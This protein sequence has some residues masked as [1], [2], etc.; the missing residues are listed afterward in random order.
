MHIQKFILKA[1]HVLDPLY[2]KVIRLQ[3]L[4][5]SSS[6]ELVFRIRLTK[7]KGKQI[8]LSDGTQIHKNDL[9]IKIHL[10]NVK[11]LYNVSQIHPEHRKA[12]EIYRMVKK[13]MPQ[14]ADF[15]K[16]HP[17]EANIKGIIGITTINK[18]FHSLGFEG[19][20]PSNRFYTSFKK[21]FQ[22][23]IFLLTSSNK[24]IKEWKKRKILYLLM[25]KEQL[26]NKHI[27]VSQE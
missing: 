12:I 8:I 13:A 16:N 10:Y 24:S 26:Y 21:F 1:W 18:G 19:I 17:Q 6:G 2:S 20:Q 22:W 3:P 25:S 14:L 23:P 15:I 27:K 4:L 11:I 9:L 7:F 5:S